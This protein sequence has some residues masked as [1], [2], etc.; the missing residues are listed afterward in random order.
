MVAAQNG[1]PPGRLGV[2][3]STIMLARMFGGAFG[4][5]VMGSVLFS[6]MRRRLLELSAGQGS[7]FAPGL[8]AKLADPQNLLDPATRASIPPSLLGQLTEIL[9]GSIRDAFIAGLCLMVLGLGVSFFMKNISE[10]RGPD[11][12]SGG[13]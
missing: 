10:A 5:A 11:G 3:T 12:C 13:G 9:R 7:G 2:A 1:A 6:G 8:I 4:I